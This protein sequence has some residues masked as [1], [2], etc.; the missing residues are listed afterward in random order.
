MKIKKAPITQRWFRCPFCGKK[1]FYYDNTA[2]CEGVYMMC[3]QCREIIE[4]RIK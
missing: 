1:L 3:K 4:I 2:Y